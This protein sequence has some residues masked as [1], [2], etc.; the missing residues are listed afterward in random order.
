MEVLLYNSTVCRLCGEENDNGTLLYS[1]ED[2]N[3]NLYEIINSY[4]P[5]K[6]SDDGE[7]PRT[8]C[9]GCTIQ[10]EATV[11]F[12]N[13]ILNGQ[14][15]LRELL[16]REKEYKKSIQSEINDSNVISENIVYEISTSE[17]LYHLEHPISLQVAGLD[18]P[19]RKRGRPSKKPKTPEQLAEEA[20]AAAAAKELEARHQAEIE[21]QENEAPEGKRKRK[22]PTRFKEV[23]QGKELEKIFLD[24]GLIDG[25]DIDIGNKARPDPLNDANVKLPEV[26]GHVETSGGPV[27]VVKGSRRGRPKGGR[28]LQKRMKCP[29]CGLVLTS[30]GRYMS[31]VAAHGPLLFR[32]EC[33]ATFESRELVDNHHRDSGHQGHTILPQR[34]HQPTDGSETAPNTECNSELQIPHNGEP[35]T[36]EGTDAGRGQDPQSA[37]AS[38][39]QTEAESELGLDLENSKQKLKCNFCEKMFSTKQSKSMH[40]KA[41]HRGEKSYKC[42]ECGVSFAYPRSLMLHAASHRKTRGADFKGFACDI[43]GKVLNHPSSV[44]YHKQSVHCPQRYVCGS[45]GKT[46]RHRQLLHRHQLVHTQHRPF[47]CKICDASFKT[48]E[49]LKNHTAL[50]SGVKKFCCDICSCRFSHKT[51]LKLH[52]RWHAGDKPFTCRTCGKSFIQKGNL[53]E[54]ERIH[55]G[56]KPFACF[57]CPRRFTTS[58]QHRLH[59]RRQHAA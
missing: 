58:S 21:V 48:K 11:E 38:E 22:A 2:N 31:H 45:C 49:N 16:D 6:L 51:S 25:E 44:E 54:H 57:L 32:C 33:G 4:L 1:N 47:R 55:T 17:G 52:L 20:A 10:V 27:V 36:S 19:K 41:I 12:L 43:C 14:K 24:E 5:I 59:Y 13:L 8:I 3:Q 50:H 53:L 9:P 7:M 15:V 35:D 29:V 56:E 30:T 23:V 18:K 34:D 40:I 26:I 46:F 37:A 28:V 39:S 42:E